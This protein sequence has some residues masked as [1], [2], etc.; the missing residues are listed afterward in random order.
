MTDT[1]NYAY[2]GQEQEDEFFGA[3]PETEEAAAGES[4]LPDPDVTPYTSWSY[5]DMRRE[6]AEITARIALNGIDKQ[7]AVMYAYNILDIIGETEYEKE[8]FTEYFMA[9]TVYFRYVLAN[10]IKLPPSP[11]AR[12]LFN[13]YASL[14]ETWGDRHYKGL[15]LSKDDTE[16]LRAD[17]YAV[18]SGLTRRAVLEEATEWRPS[19]SPRLAP[20]EAMKLVEIISGET[21]RLKG[22]YL[23]VNK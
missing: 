5:T 14:A 12:T 10:D 8:R 16:K 13:E 1:E 2:P 21:E 19:P 3:E 9:R 23:L 6:F 7:I 4:R 20:L 22:K 17:S 18:L 15:E 11:E